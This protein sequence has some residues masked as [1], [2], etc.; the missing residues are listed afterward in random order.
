MHFSWPATNAGALLCTMDGPTS[1]YSSFRIQFEWNVLKEDKMD[2]PTQVKSWRCGSENTL[3]MIVLLEGTIR[4][5]SDWSRSWKPENRVVPPDKTMLE[6]RSLCRSRSHDLID[7]WS[8]W[9]IPKWTRSL[10]DLDP[11]SVC[12]C[13]FL[14]IN[15]M[16]QVKIHGSCLL[17]F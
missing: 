3:T 4:D 7:L 2:P 15:S 12:K 9:W 13:K 5:N 16:Y 14:N 6:N 1:A 17:S 8:A 11:K 10:A